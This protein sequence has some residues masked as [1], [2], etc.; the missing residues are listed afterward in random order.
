[1]KRPAILVLLLVAS[2]LSAQTSRP[3]LLTLEERIAL[4]TILNWQGNV[5]T[6]AGKCAFPPPPRRPSGH[7]PRRLLRRTHTSRI[8]FAP[9]SMR[10]IVCRIF[11]SCRMA[12]KELARIDEYGRRF[13]YKAAA[14]VAGQKDLTGRRGTVAPPPPEPAPAAS[15]QP[16]V[17]QR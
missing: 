13:C 2:A 10:Q 5:C 4:R 8:V 3:W 14:R 1:M 7:S 16:P 15:A 9:R 6:I 12:R 11:E 17:S